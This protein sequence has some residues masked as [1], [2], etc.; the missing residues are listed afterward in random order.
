MS[1]WFSTLLS[2]CFR[3]CTDLD[4]AELCGSSYS[5]FLASL[6]KGEFVIAA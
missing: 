3:I 2:I 1:V 6:L 4:S 5:R